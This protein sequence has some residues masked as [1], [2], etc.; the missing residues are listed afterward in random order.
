MT[1]KKLGMDDDEFKTFCE[2]FW[3]GTQDDKDI[4][5]SGM[6]KL[7]LKKLAV[8]NEHIASLI[9]DVKSN[10]LTLSGIDAAR[11][12]FF[13]EHNEALSRY[14]TLLSI[15]NELLRM[16]NELKDTTDKIMKTHDTMKFENEILRK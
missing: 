3:F 4:S 15:H 10:G 7:I 13:K 6:A 2:L 5:K 12:F 1:T 11:K 14:D 9:L 16:Y 8:K